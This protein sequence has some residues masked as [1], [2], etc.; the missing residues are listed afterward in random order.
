M[1]DHIKYEEIPESL[2]R[3]IKYCINSY[4]Q[5]SWED[6]V[7][8]LDEQIGISEGDE[9]LLNIVNEFFGGHIALGHKLKEAEYRPSRP[10]ETVMDLLEDY[11]IDDLE[12]DDIEK[13]IKC[14]DW[15]NTRKVIKGVE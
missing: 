5:G 1:D 2:K 14:S 12:P 6:L 9:M 15:S 3:A 13:Y 10:H 4:M 8:W 7:D 11:L